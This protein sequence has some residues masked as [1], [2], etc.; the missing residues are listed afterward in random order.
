MPVRTL[1]KSFYVI[2]FIALLFG[3]GIGMFV[4]YS[5]LLNQN[6]FIKHHNIYFYDSQK[7]ID[8]WFREAEQMDTVYL[9]SLS[10]EEKKDSLIEFRK[11]I[12]L[13]V[14]DQFA[15]FQNSSTGGYQITERNP[16]RPIAEF[17]IENSGQVTR[18]LDSRVLEDSMLPHA[19]AFFTYA[20][21]GSFV[22]GL[23]S[24]ANQ[25]GTTNRIYIDT[26]GLG[27][28][29]TMIINERGKRVVHEMNG[30]TWEVKPEK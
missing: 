27:L 25:D 23:Y 19:T 30:M 16:N 5:L 17:S 14:I 24:T 1:K 9:D 15:I 10:A 26:K 4:E 29:D 13:V 20:K 7:K 2:A 11:N 12:P 6:R 22:K 8:Q 21:D 18:R 28:F 3:I